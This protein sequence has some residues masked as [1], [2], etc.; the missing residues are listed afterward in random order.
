MG[1]R[2]QYVQI[3]IIQRPKDARSMYAFVFIVSLVVRMVSAQML[4]SV[5]PDDVAAL[6][7]ATK[8]N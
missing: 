3:P 1:Y 8:K 5:S 4:A 2:M 6:E 7:R